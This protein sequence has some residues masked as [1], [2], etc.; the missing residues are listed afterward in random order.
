MHEDAPLLAEWLGAHELARVAG[1]PWKFDGEL[2]A[3]DVTIVEVTG[4]SL[5]LAGVFDE[6]DQALRQENAR[7]AYQNEP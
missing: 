6:L 2:E 7:K 1:W 3:D 5:P 4:K